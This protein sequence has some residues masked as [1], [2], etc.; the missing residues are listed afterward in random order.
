MNPVLADYERQFTA[1]RDRIG[2]LVAA[3]SEEDLQWHPA[4]GE[5]SIVECLEHLNSGWM[6]LPKLDRKIADARDRNLIGEGP[7]RQ[8]FLGW[9]YVRL[10]EPP[11]RFKINAPRQ[12]RPRPE[13]P[14]EEVVPRILQLQEELA[15]RVRA[16]DGL[17][18]GAVRM[19]SPISR[20]FKMTLGQWFAFLA[21]HERR[22]LWQAE[23]VKRGNLAVES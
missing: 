4:P 6:V 9:L 13:R 18:V 21:A 23:N 10:V 12:F 2:R 1:V 11:V 5:W 3:L 7:F 15:E 14:S 22:H 17:D 20:R 19:R 8:P 16:C